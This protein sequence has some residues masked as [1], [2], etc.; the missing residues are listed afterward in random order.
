MYGHVSVIESG[1]IVASRGL[2]LPQAGDEPEIPLVQVGDAV[3]ELS[4]RW[5]VAQKMKY[6]TQYTWSGD[7]TGLPSILLFSLFVG[8]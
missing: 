3:G 7:S 4:R 2:T 5:A 1:E 8:N 6:T